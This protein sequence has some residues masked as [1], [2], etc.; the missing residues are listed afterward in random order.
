MRRYIVLLLITGIVWAQTD[1]DKLVLKNG[2][3]YLGEYV[4]T[5]KKMVYFKSQKEMSIRITSIR[6]VQTLQLKDGTLIKTKIEKLTPKE[7]SVYEAKKDAKRDAGKWVAYPFLALLSS[8]GLGTATFFICEDGFK[9]R[10]E[11]SLISATIVGSLGL[12]GSYNLF[13]RLV[14][15]NIDGT[16]AENIE[17]YK[18]TYSSE[19]EKRKFKNIII[20]TGLLGLMA[21][22]GLVLVL[23]SIGDGMSDYDACFDPRC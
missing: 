11:S 6:D 19:F 7:I 20:S 15:K 13:N 9:M 10:D 12:V 22:V 4:K 17:I 3:E 23:K 21:S 14:K 16:S 8:G 18:E 2:K 1:Y 5:E